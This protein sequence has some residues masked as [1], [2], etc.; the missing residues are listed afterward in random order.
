MSFVRPIGRV[1]AAT[2]FAALLAAGSPALA[3]TKW[4]IS[5]PWGPW[6]FTL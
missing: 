4:D 3:Q 1:L 6:N 5:L 2:G